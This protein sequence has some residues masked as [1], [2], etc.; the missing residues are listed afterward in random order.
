MDKDLI[1][2]GY[3]LDRSGSM[4]ARVGDVI[5]GFNGLME[6]QRRAPG[7]ANVTIVGFD[8]H[9][10]ES[11]RCVIANG[12]DISL[13]R[14][15]DHA[16]YFARGGT[17]LFDAVA[18]TIDLIGNR[19][20]KTPEHMR[21]SKVLLTV[22][23]DGEEN[24]S[25]EYDRGH[26]GAARLKAKIKHQQDL[27]SWDV[28]FMGANMDA[29]LTGGTDFGLHVG[30]AIN[31]AS[32]T[33]GVAGAYAVMNNYALRS[34]S[35]DSAQDALVS[36]SFSSL[37]RQV[38]MGNDPAPVVGTVIPDVVVPTVSSTTPKP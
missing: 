25:V 2:L 20:S 18:F 36:N 4:A 29:V 31:W 22:M 33:K 16:T 34:R 37:E 38:T 5:G 15:L 17:P 14:P 28:V 21:P 11:P 24:A 19:L 6:N 35:F 30:K 3:V 32:S 23:T 9:D 26:G 27:Y 13:I 10:A 1:E 7:R 8:S 12:V